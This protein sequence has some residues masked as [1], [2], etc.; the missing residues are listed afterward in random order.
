M[1]TTPTSP[2]GPLWRRAAAIGYDSLLLAAL[3][4]AVSLPI[5]LLAGGNIHGPARTLFQ[6]CLLTVIGAFFILFW[7]H[8]GQTVGMRA[9]RLRVVSVDGTRISRRQAV[10]RF[11]VAALSWLCL[12]AGFLAGF[13]DREGR[14]WHDRASGTRLI[15]LPKHPGSRHATQ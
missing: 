3:L 7:R 1:Q 9:W 2:S 8:G 13:I 4:L 10:L 12:G 14:T 6:L 5:T 11:A 15:L